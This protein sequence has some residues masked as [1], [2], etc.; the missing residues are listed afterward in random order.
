MKPTTRIRT[1]DA[2]IDAAIKHARENKKAGTRI[3][4]AHF[5][6]ASDTIVVKLST[7]ATVMVPRTAIPGFA[8]IDP[9]QLAD[10]TRQSSGLSVWSKAAD[11]GLRIET[12]LQIAA[13]PALTTAGGIL[14]RTSTPAK[15]AAAR[16]NGRKGGRPRKPAGRSL[17]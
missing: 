11:A 8:S 5:D 16:T 1:T 15:A 13:G 17:Q 12:L 7:K 9:R 10:L 3:L 4:A 6:R 14:G 2:Q